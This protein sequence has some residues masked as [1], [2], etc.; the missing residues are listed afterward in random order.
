MQRRPI[1][2]AARPSRPASTRTGVMLAILA[3]V[4][5]LFSR[6]RRAR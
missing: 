4:V 6:P 3:A 5:L 2:G 1:P